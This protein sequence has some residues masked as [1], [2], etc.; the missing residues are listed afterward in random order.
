[1]ATAFELLTKTVADQ[2]ALQEEKKPKVKADKYRLVEGKYE[3]YRMFKIPEHWN[4]DNIVI[5]FDSLF[6][7]GEL[8]EVDMT[9]LCE[10]DGRAQV[11]DCDDDIEEWFDCEDSEDDEE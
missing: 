6:Y 5:Q 4:T 1:M 2:L 7:D 3:S 8:M 11:E 10:G 9:D